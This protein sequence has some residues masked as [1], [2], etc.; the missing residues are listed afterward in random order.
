MDENSWREKKDFK[1]GD[2]VIAKRKWNNLQKGHTSS[3]HIIIANDG[4]YI[5]AITGS[6]TKPDSKNNRKRIHTK[7]RNIDAY[8]YPKIYKFEYNEIL[9]K[10][11][12]VSSST[13]D[14][15][16][17][18]LDS[19][20]SYGMNMDNEYYRFLI[21][22]A[23]LKTGDIVKINND[24]LTNEKYVII[25]ENLESYQVMEIANNKLK[26][27]KNE[28]FYTIRY[29]VII[30][31]SKK[32]KFIRLDTLDLKETEELL[33]KVKIKNIRKDDNSVIPGN[34][35]RING[36]KYYVYEVNNSQASI[37]PVSTTIN[38]DSKFIYNKTNIHINFS[39]RKLINAKQSDIEILSLVPYSIIL[40]IK[41]KY[42]EYQNNKKIKN[43]KN[44]ISAVYR[45]IS[46]KPH[47]IQIL[48]QE[49][50]SIIALDLTDYYN[51]KIR[52]F[53]GNMR[54]LEKHPIGYLS[55][56]DYNNITSDIDEIFK[57]EYNLNIPKHSNTRTRKEINPKKNEK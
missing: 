48:Y 11:G 51:G 27:N 30:N 10:I 47:L 53:R 21:N 42:E 6:T 34:I 38:Y 13:K 57:K 7:I 29:D 23:D 43:R 16:S 41:G 49:K 22:P 5:Y 39:R 56:S 55:I 33:L 14:Y 45:T 20:I 46:V 2:I 12:E 40:K 50:N 37:F 24:T 36:E 31:V 54:V 18:K 17:R 8:Y 44:Q 26:D 19:E 15:I 35:I 28:P 9:F 25:S 4:E 3:P 32:Q 1:F 52:I